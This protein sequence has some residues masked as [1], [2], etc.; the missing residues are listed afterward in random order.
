MNIYQRKGFLKL[1]IILLLVVILQSLKSHAIEGKNDNY[2]PL[3][4]YSLYTYEGKYKDKTYKN[5]II[6]NTSPE[7]T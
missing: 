4:D 7:S 2:F 1:I 6:L 5:T 3:V